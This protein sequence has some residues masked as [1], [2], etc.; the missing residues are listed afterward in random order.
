M[1]LLE[2]M[3]PRRWLLLTPCHV[4][5]CDGTSIFRAGRCSCWGTGV[6]HVLTL[7][8]KLGPEDVNGTE[9]PF[10]PPSLSL[11]FFYTALSSL[12]ATLLSQS[13]SMLPPCSLMPPHRLPIKR[14]C[15]HIDIPPP[16]LLPVF[17]ILINQDRCTCLSM[18]RVAISCKKEK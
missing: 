5:R 11:P 10:P 12:K 18:L 17:I 9:F 3:N 7:G 16:R 2:L 14:S 6:F 4:E 8:A 1:W 15:P 13:K